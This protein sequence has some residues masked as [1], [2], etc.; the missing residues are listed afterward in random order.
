MPNV[1]LHRCAE[2][3]FVE[4]RKLT[5]RDTG[6]GVVIV[7]PD[8]RVLVLPPMPASPKTAELSPQLPDIVPVDRSCNI[9]VISNT[10]F[11]LSNDG[12][13]PAS[14]KRKLS[15]FWVSDRLKAGHQVWV[16]EDIVGSSR[17]FMDSEFSLLDSGMLPFR[18]DWMAAASAPAPGERYSCMIDKV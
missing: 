7:G 9:A 11:T 8:R 4:V 18:N 12:A 14:G 15:R 10:L 16:F 1:D 5:S 2:D 13:V 3:V 17:W 6:G